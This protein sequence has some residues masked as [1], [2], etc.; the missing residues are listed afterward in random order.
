M[1]FLAEIRESKTVLA[2]LI[3]AALSQVALVLAVNGFDS[4]PDT[5][6]YLETAK[7]YKD[8][9]GE[10]YP[11]RIQRPLQILTV[12]LVEPWLGVDGAFVFINSLFYIASIPFFYLFSKRLLVNSRDAVASTILFEF[13]FCVLYWGLAILTD[14][15]VWLVM[16]VSFY[17]LHRISVDWKRR[18]IL[19]LATIIGIGII[20][21]ESVVAAGLMLIFMILVKHVRESRPFI[22]TSIRVAVPLLI[23]AAPFLAVQV[24][25]L[26]HFGPGYSFFD[27]HLFHST[28]T[29]RGELWY[30]PITFVIA[31]N[32]ALL[33][34]PFGVRQFLRSNTM[35]S[36]KSYLASL[37]ILLLPV[38]VFEQYSPRLSFLVFPL[39][40]PVAAAGMAR[41]PKIHNRDF[42][43]WAALAL[44][45]VAGNSVALFGDD[46]REMLGIWSR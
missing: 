35:Y 17:L 42:L 41:L 37:L 9:S 44:V 46:I 1:G 33:F 13:S 38:V 26:V 20:N 24:A 18:D 30:L 2:V 22:Q 28:G 21:K 15:L 39:V 23:M 36:A 12:L 8:G 31:F 6:E 25:I 32:I 11:L 43:I 7:W 14:M 10:E 16:C 27:Y 29:V 40:L 3:V 5:D 45:V 4:F 19:M 34:Y